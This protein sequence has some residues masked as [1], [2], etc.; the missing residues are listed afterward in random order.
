MPL[1]LYSI[2]EARDLMERRTD[3]SY[4]TEAVRKAARLGTLICFWV[5]EEPI[6]T[7]ENIMRYLWKHGRYKPKFSTPTGTEE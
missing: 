3:H 4:D 7:E 6:F 2:H 1:T 5:G